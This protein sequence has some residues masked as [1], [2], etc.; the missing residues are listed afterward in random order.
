MT[1]AKEKVTNFLLQNCLL[2]WQHILKVIKI[3]VPIIIKLRG[4]EVNYS[5]PILLRQ[6]DSMEDG[7]VI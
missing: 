4:G 2:V 6:Q 3:S 7:K 5:E 1:T